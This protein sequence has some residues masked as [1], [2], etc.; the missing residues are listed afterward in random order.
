[1]GGAWGKFPPPRAV[2]E[3]AGLGSTWRTPLLNWARDAPTNPKA[4]KRE[5]HP[6]TLKAPRLGGGPCLSLPLC[7]CCETESEDANSSQSPET[8]THEIL[9][10]WARNRRKTAACATCSCCWC[11]PHI[12]RMHTPPAF[13]QG[14]AV[15]RLGSRLAPK[16]QQPVRE[17]HRH[18]TQSQSCDGC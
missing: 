14:T 15:P 1:M 7:H 17:R 16:Q 5:L 18:R 13:P 10:L 9:D 3:R 12:T 4:G 2:I 6:G 11:N 8:R